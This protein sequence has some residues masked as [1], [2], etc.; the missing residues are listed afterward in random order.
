MKDFIGRSEYTFIHI[1]KSGGTSFNNS[2]PFIDSRRNHERP[3]FYRDPN[4]ASKYIAIFRNPFDRC[5]SHYKHALRTWAWNLKNVPYEKF[6]EYHLGRYALENTFSRMICGH[7][8]PSVEETIE[9]LKDFF[10]VIDFDNYQ[11]DCK[12]LMN[13]I[14][15]NESILRHDNKTV[16]R[17]PTNL[18]FLDIVKKH[19]N[20]DLPVYTWFKLQRKQNAKTQQG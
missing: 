9:N 16:S 19:N 12:K 2:F 15:I 1:P 14:G 4:I 7:D 5:W 6:M 20:I 10:F 17:T 8:N 3:H 18:K 11:E 13:S